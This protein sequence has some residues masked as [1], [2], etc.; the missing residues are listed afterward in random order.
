MHI[1][2]TILD[3]WKRIKRSGDAKRIAETIGVTPNLIY[4]AF[5]KGKCSRRVF[6]A[7]SAYYVEAEKKYA[8]L[9]ERTAHLVTNE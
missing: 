9:L 6:D 3:R 8:D 7:I 1:E 4:I 5:T 2:Q